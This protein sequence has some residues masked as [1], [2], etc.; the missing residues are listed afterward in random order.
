M[1][2]TESGPRVSE[3][4]SLG[5]ELTCC[6]SA[7]CGLSQARAIGG[8]GQSRRP[9]LGAE[10]ER[11]YSRKRTED[12]KDSMDLVKDGDGLTDDGREW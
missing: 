6:P 7:V 4:P 10:R 9:S 5:G 1:D 8:A 2:E 12:R 3:A 11:E